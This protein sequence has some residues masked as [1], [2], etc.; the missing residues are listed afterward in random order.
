VLA[1]RD[2]W[3]NAPAGLARGSGFPAEHP[4][5][6]ATCWAVGILVIFMPLA[7]SRYRKAASR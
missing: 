1:L 6:L 5:L 4:I 3:G 2:L 7:I